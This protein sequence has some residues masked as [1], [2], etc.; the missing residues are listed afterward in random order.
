MTEDK[1]DKAYNTA[2]EKTIDMLD[3]LQ[4]E[5][6]NMQAILVGILEPLLWVAHK[7]APDEDAVDEV[8]K[9]VSNE[10]A[11]HHRQEKMSGWN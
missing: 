2:R 1:W 8:L 3:G 5:G 7:C 4:G 6:M 11:K 9:A 10:M